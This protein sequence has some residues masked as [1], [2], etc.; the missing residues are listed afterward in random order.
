MDIL[1]FL[2]QL[3]N[4]LAWPIVAVVL[5]LLLRSP[6]S[7]LLLLIAKIKYKDLEVWFSKEMAIIKAEAS[8]KELP[9]LT[10]E[11]D[12]IAKKLIQD[13][14]VQAV[15][16]AWNSLEKAIYEK[17]KELFPQ[18]SVQYQRLTP[19]RAFT[20]LMLT[21]A[22]SPEIEETINKLSILRN[23]LS[24]TIEYTISAR[25]AIAY[26]SLTKRIQKKIEALTELPTVNLTPLTIMV[27]E[28]NHLIDSGR[29]KDITL[30]DVKHKIDRG[31]MTFPLYTS[32]YPGKS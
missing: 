2:T 6:I 23:Q 11:E 13:S 1:T 7:K 12:R 29:Y 26:I 4:S 8:N 16:I 18:N 32:I 25:D 19:D 20:E 24:H 15:L 21:G 31:A 9:N 10:E 5:V 27:L 28:L 30:E 17:L 22:M 14:P 3:V